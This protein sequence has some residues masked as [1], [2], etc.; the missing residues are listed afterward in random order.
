M[1]DGPRPEQGPEREWLMQ[2]FAVA[3]YR[4]V[5]FREPDQAGLAD[6][7]RFLGSAPAPFE[8]G[9]VSVFRCPEFKSKIGRFLESYGHTAPLSGSGAVPGSL[10]ALANRFGS[11]KGSEHGEAHRYTALYDLILS[12]YRGLDI[13]FLELGLCIGGPEVGGPVERTVASPSL[14]MWLE[15]FPRARIF[16]FDISD[17]SHLHH[18]R[19]AFVRGDAGSEADLARLA[20]AAAGFD[21]VIDD[22]SHAS[23]H[24]QLA[25]K[26]LFPKLRAGGVYVIEDLHWQ[27]PVYEEVWGDGPKTA[28][29]MISFFDGDEYR[30]NALLSEEFMTAARRQ[31]DAFSW[32]P[33]FRGGDSRPKLLVFSKQSAA[34]NESFPA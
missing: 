16:G 22:A 19:F 26:H 14:Q 24:Q 5:L 9:L 1:N 20:A 15:Y 8:E 13:D 28:E 6:W 11:D 23:R 12:R 10:T 18:P 2:Q 34:A 32:F 31:L 27:P 4:C 17:F 7:M 25:F 21:V 30:D 33:G 29:F 3:L